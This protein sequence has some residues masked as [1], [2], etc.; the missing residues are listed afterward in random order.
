ML[1][2]FYNH[3]KTIKVFSESLR[4]FQFDCIGDNLTDDERGIGM[5]VN[6]FYYSSRCSV[7]VNASDFE[8]LVSSGRASGI[9]VLQC[10]TSFEPDVALC[11]VSAISLQHRS[12]SVCMSFVRL[13]HHNR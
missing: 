12:C 7:E 3:E 6:T 8:T 13:G 11:S 10:S 5:Y 4:K 2:A 1:N 9:K